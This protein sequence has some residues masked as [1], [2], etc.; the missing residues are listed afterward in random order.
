VSR[1]SLVATR[2]LASGQTLEPRDLTVKRPGT[3]VPP[4][5][6]AEVIGRKLARAVAADMPLTDA[7][8]G[9]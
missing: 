5:R 9:S 1:Q 2:D 8:L 7:D 4:Y 3:G 6:L